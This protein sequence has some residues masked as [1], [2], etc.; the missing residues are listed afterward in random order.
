M[1]LSKDAKHLLDLII[2][3]EPTIQGRFYFTQAV[4]S[5]V[6]ASDFGITDER[7]WAALY[8]LRE[9][10]CIA[11]LDENWSALRLCDMGIHYREY[12]WLDRKEQ[13]KNW[14]SGCVCGILTA[15]VVEALRLF[16]LRG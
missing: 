12:Q 5:Q 6:S 13:I 15:V 1:K 11:P 7:L 3:M 9:E 4:I 14:I 10:Q 8:R 2:R 16:I